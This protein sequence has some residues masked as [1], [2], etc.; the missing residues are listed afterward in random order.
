MFKYFHRPSQNEVIQTSHRIRV[1]LVT[2][3]LLHSTGGR[4]SCESRLLLQQHPAHLPSSSNHSNPKPLLSR[5]TSDSG[6]PARS[7]PETHERAGPAR[8]ST[9]PPAAHFTTAERQALSPVSTRTPL[10]CSRAASPGVCN[11]VLNVLADG[12]PRSP[13][14]A[15][16]LE[17]ANPRPTRRAASCGFL[18]RADALM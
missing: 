5:C 7:G 14:T 6:R 2:Q 8:C 10:V 12:E 3:Q 17:R 18:R 13:L 1:C 11:W 4:A 15:T 16:T 9:P